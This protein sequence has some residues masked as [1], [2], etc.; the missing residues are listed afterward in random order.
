MEVVTLPS[1]IVSLP[2]GPEAPKA[3][4]VAIGNFDGVHI[5]H[6]AVIEKLKELAGSE[7][8]GIYT[9]Y[10]HPR[11][12][13]NPKVGLSY[14]TPLQEKLGL[15]DSLGVSLVWVQTFDM[16]FAHVSAEAFIE[17]VLVETLR[18]S[19]L[20]VGKDFCFGHGRRGNIHML[21]R[22]GKRF[23][24]RVH[25]P[26]MVCRYG[27]P[28][29]SSWIK[30]ILAAHRVEQAAELLGRPYRIGGVVGH[31]AGRGRS[32]GF[33]TANLIIDPKKFMPAHGV[34]AGWVHLGQKTY[35]AVANL[36]QK[37]TFKDTSLALEVHLLE[38][39]GKLY[40][41]SLTFDFIKFLRHQM[42]F[43]SPSELA[44]QIQNDTQE[45]LAALGSH[46]DIRL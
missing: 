31:G 35:R 20:V 1:D 29:S 37:P 40:G 46:T 34:Y 2:K 9:L 32:L 42:P 19:W 5:G 27:T 13:F 16:D 33:P 44:R 11:E 14:L 43:S 18:V 30:E 24:F 41:Q 26:E 36:G 7:P 6:Q 21:E 10:P 3:S 4:A 17:R 12:V 23:G 39:E 22:M 45:A 25:T 28:V 8:F 15:L 38:F